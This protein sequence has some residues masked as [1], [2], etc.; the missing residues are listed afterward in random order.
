M[1]VVFLALCDVTMH[2]R[3]ALCCS[4]VWSAFNER[5]ACRKR[6]FSEFMRA[7]TGGG[8]ACVI[9][10]SARFS[11]GSAGCAAVS[12]A[13]FSRCCGGCAGRCS[14][15]FSRSSDC[16]SSPSFRC[17]AA[18]SS[19]RCAAASSL[20]SLF[21]QSH[22]QRAILLYTQHQANFRDIIVLRCRNRKIE[23]LDVFDGRDV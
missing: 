17:A 18:A 19:C 3:I 11:R 2:S 22:V 6:L 13:R 23:K 5:T 14:S 4:A 12:S 15:R 16:A 10:S 20:C 9:C 1:C 21:N 8:G 7:L